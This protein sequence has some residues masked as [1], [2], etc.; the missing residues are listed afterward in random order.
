[1]RLTA[2]VKSARA[3]AVATGLLVAAFGVAPGVTPSLAGP[4]TGQRPASRS[5]WL[6]A[7]ASAVRSCR[8]RYFGLFN[9]RKHRQ[10]YVSNLSVRNMT[11]KAAIRSLHDATLVGWPPNIRTRGFRCHILNGGGGGATDRC[12]HDRPYKAFRVSIGT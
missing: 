2:A 4:P 9:F 5:P 3:L 7:T 11:C 6:V 12:V 1:M 10:E 8:P